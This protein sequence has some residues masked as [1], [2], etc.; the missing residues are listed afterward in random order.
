[1]PIPS[2]F[3]LQHAHIPLDEKLLKTLSEKT[4]GRYFLASDTETLRQVYATIDKLEKSKEETLVFH[5]REEKFAFFLWPGVFFLLLELFF[6]LTRFRR[7][8]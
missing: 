3:G 1:M 8:P 6:R 4:S 2:Q 7:I 5:Q